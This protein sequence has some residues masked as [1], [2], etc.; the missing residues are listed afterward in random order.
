MSKVHRVSSLAEASR[1]EALGADLIGVSMAVDNHF[2]DGREVGAEVA[3]N[4][5]QCLTQAQLVLEP[6]RELTGSDLLILA[7]KAGAGWIQTPFFAAPDSQT[8]EALADIGIG[9][10]VSRLEADYDMDPTWILGPVSDLGEPLPDLIELEIVPSFT[11][12][13]RFLTKESSKQTDELQVEDL[14]SLAQKSPLLISVDLMPSNISGI[15]A[16]IPSAHG[17]SFTLGRLA[18]DTSGLHVLAPDSAA[19]LLEAES[20]R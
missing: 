15:L 1:F 6:P 14:E 12:S 8:R 18:T 3:V 7:Q 5:A 20:K 19:R 17:L 16:A 13:W 2:A 11:D 9:L 4:L 10:I